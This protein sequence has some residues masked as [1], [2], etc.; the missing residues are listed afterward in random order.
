[1]L[2][3]SIKNG[4]GVADLLASVA[5]VWVPILGALGAFLA[6]LGGLL[7]WAIRSGHKIVTTLDKH[8]RT[9]AIM[10]KAIEELSAAIG[11]LGDRITRLSETNQRL[12]LQLVQREK[13]HARLEG[14]FE[15]IGTSLVD[16]VGNLR[17][18]Q[19]SIDAA[20]IVLGQVAPDYV[21]Q[22]NGK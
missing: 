6:F 3:V 19:G 9:D 4:A 12:E 15:L 10:R 13:D 8:E 17:G 7:W 16:T 11:K 2:S 5:S 18:L 21:R 20:W 14:K 1:M 22:R